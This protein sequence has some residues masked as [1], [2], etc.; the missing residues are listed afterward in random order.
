MEELC[1]HVTMRHVI[2][3][4]GYILIKDSGTYNIKF[5]E[6]GLA[7]RCRWRREQN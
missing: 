6:T 7:Y 1:E 3:H 5:Q 2:L 4:S